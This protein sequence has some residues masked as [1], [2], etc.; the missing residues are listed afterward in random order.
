MTGARDSFWAGQLVARIDSNNWPTRVKFVHE[1]AKLELR[2]D[3]HIERMIGRRNIYGR[4]DAAI[5]TTV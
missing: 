5:E 4:L 3:D 1:V 2:V